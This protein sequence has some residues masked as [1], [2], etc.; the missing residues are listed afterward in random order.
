MSALSFALVSS[1]S[2]L[3]SFKP[4]VLVPADSVDTGEKLCLQVYDSDR[5]NADD[6]VS[7]VQCFSV[8]RSRSDARSPFFS[9]LLSS[10]SSRSTSQLSSKLETL[11]TSFP[12]T[13][14]E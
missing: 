11:P 13:T 12:P 14:L 8:S 5:W 6:S 3:T 7:L 4:L 9:L 10:E 1:S 2:K